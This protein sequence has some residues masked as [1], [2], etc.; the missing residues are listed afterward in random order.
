MK[1][2]SFSEPKVPTQRFDPKEVIPM[3]NT[4]LKN[5]RGRAAIMVKMKITSG[6]HQGDIYDC[7]Q[8]CLIL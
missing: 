5:V 4:H 7:A 8:L 6:I 1:D 2:G 3:E